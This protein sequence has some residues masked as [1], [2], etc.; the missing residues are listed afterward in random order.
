[1]KVTVRI[2]KPEGLELKTCKVEDDGYIT[3]RS[4]KGKAGWRP[5]ITMVEAKHGW[6]GRAKFFT[7]IFYEAEETWKIDPTVKETEMPKWTK[8]QSTRFI[9]AKVLEKAGEEEKN[10]GVGMGIWIIAILV[11]AMGI[12]Q[13]LISTGRLRI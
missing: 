1:M 13:I 9:N 10:K 2:H 8:Q 5:K 7:D 6:F 3:L 12:V 4:G 11:I